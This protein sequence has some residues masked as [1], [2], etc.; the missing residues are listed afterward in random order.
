MLDILLFVYSVLEFTHYQKQCRVYNYF[1]K[2]YVEPNISNNELNSCIDALLT[3]DTDFFE[4]AQVSS[5]SNHITNRKQLCDALSYTPDEIAPS[6]KFKPVRSELTWSYTPFILDTLMKQ[7]RV[8][9]EQYM[10]WNGYKRKTYLT[11][12]GYYNV[13]TYENNASTKRPLIFFPGAGFGAILY[14]HVAKLFNRTVH[15]IEVP[16][17]CYATPNTNSHATGRGLS[18]IVEQCVGDQEHDVASHSFGSFHTSMYLNTSYTLQ[19]I[20]N[21]YICEGFTNPADVL[22]NHMM[23]FVNTTHFDK[24]PAL[25]YSYVKFIL[26]VKLLIQNIYIQSFTKRFVRIIDVNWKDYGKIKIKYIYSEN[27]EMM[28]SKYI[29]RKTSPD[30]YYCIPNGKHGSCFFGRRRKEFIQTLFNE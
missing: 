25:Q 28:D 1:N 15:M 16:N 3:V 14:V 4:R 23:P 29:M 22:V 6:D 26:L 11:N 27:D 19:K 10:R 18:D 24:L 12:D 21:V 8:L 17:I 9:G 30:L 7:A 5:I 20:Q 13:F 2:L